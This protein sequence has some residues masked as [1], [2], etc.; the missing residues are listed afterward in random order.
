MCTFHLSTDLNTPKDTTDDTSS[1]LIH[2]VDQDINSVDN[3]SDVN[4]SQ[5]IDINSINLN[6][7]ASNDCESPSGSDDIATRVRAR[8]EKARKKKVHKKPQ[9]F[10]AR[11]LIIGNDKQI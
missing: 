4:E 9:H 10:T 8:N 5:R 3:G 2:T 1:T 6:N 7:H 11:N